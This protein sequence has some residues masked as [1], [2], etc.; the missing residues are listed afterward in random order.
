MSSILDQVIEAALT[1][2]NTS[3]PVG[4]PAAVRTRETDLDV[5]SLPAISLRPVEMTSTRIRSRV[6]PL[7]EH[8]LTLRIDV[9]SKA[10]SGV[11]ADK[12]GDPCLVH[13]HDRL[14]DNRLGGLSIEAA[15][16]KVQWTYEDTESGKLARAAVDF[17]L[18]FTTAVQSAE[19]RT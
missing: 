7:E 14:S 4:I 11:S 18:A 16:S 19:S 13:V 17:L 5:A 9:I 2:L 10:S 3:R 1:A 12:A 15:W 8:R 6:G